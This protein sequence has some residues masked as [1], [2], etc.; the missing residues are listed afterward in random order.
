M[1]WKTAAKMALVTVGVMFAAN[2]LAALNPAA[3]KLL[4]GQAVAPVG[5]APGVAAPAPK[6]LKV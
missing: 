4:K 5:E 1:N 6:I 3:R 2:W